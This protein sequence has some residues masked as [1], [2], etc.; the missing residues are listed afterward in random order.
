MGYRIESVSGEMLTVS[1][2][3]E[4]GKH[5]YTKQISKRAFMDEMYEESF[6]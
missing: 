6:G 3:A 1:T 4:D 2:P 5:R